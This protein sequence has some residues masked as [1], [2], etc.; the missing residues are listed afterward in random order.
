MEGP[1]AK[2]GLFW[3][4]LIWL[5]RIRTSMCTTEKVRIKN[6]LFFIGFVPIKSTVLVSTGNIVSEIFFLAGIS[7]N[8]SSS[9]AKAIT[10]ISFGM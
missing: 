1:F 8:I 5:G 6:T 7:F 3:F 9:F 2:A 4:Y 10:S